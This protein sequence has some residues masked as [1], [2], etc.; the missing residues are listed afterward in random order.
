MR[1]FLV[2]F[3]FSVLFSLETGEE[4]Y[5]NESTGFYLFTRLLCSNTKEPSH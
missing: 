5:Y 3:S 2:Y 4:Y 1:L